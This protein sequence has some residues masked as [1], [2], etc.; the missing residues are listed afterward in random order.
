MESKRHVLDLFLNTNNPVISKIFG[1]N[2]N[3]MMG[4]HNCIYYVTLYDTKGNQEEEQFP[5]LKHCTALA[6]RIRKLRQEE[7]EIEKQFGNNGGVRSYSQTPNFSV[8]LGHVLSGII[9]HLSS[10]VISAPMA[11]HLVDKDS[12]FHF[13]HDF[14]H[15]LLSQFESWLRDEDIHFHF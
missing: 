15:I 9:A 5:F 13:S 10:T 3:V 7:M 12:S 4:D 11:W 14:F 6:K 2:N 8:G 1:Y